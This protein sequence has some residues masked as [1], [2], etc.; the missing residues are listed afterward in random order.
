MGGPWPTP[1]AAGD[2]AATAAIT[3]H[4]YCT[5][6]CGRKNKPEKHLS[7]NCKMQMAVTFELIPKLNKS[8]GQ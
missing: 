5:V 8:K 4:H 2:A 1:P 3:C 7:F 6:S